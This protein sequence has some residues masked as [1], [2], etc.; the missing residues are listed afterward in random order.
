MKKII[1]IFVAL[2]T[3]TTTLKAQEN[4]FAKGDVAV[5]LGVG[6]LSGLY[7]GS[8]YTNKMP[9]ISVS[10]EYGIKDDVLDIGSIGVGGYLGY[11][12]AKWESAWSGSTYGWKY[13]NIIVGA[14]GSFHYPLVD[15]LDTYAG[16]MLGYNIVSVKDIGTTPIG[17]SASGSSA[18]FSGYVGGRY[19]FN[20]KFAVMGELGTGIAYLNLGI[21]FKL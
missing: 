3:L 7:T 16:V 12:S 5:N 20:D 13:T 17:F 21:A 2:L 15:K 18:I 8:Y 9:P 11:A 1:T 19:Y 14:R 10:V 4:L 6:L